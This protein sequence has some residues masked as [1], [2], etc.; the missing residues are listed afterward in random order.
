MR[1]L[2]AKRAPRITVY[3]VAILG[4]AAILWFWVFPYLDRTFVNRP[5]LG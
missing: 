5:A 2:P 3:V 4:Y 1:L